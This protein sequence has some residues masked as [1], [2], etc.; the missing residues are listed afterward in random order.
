LNCAKPDISRDDRSRK[1]FRFNES[2]PAN[3][4]LRVAVC[5][6]VDLH[7]EVAQRLTAIEQQMKIEQSCE[8]NER[9]LSPRCGQRGNRK[10]L[11]EFFVT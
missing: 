10:E 9:T 7:C 6:D 11:L 3:K 2:L 1:L 8:E 4:H 5:R